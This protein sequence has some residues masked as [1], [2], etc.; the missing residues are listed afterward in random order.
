MRI[1]VALIMV[2]AAALFLACNGDS[3]A[4]PRYG[5]NLR[6]AVTGTAGIASATFFSSKDYELQDEFYDLPTESCLPL[7][8][9]TPSPTL[10]FIDVGAQ[11]SLLS[12][13]EI[14][15]MA[16]SVTTSSV[17]YSGSAPSDEFTSRL[18]SLSI[19][20]SPQAPSA[21]IPG[22]A[23]VA[24]LPQVT[25]PA[26]F[27]SS[28]VGIGNATNLEVTWIV[29]DGPIVLRFAGNDGH[30]FACR[31]TD[32]GEF[33][34]PQASLATLSSAGVF[35]V[36]RLGVSGRST[37]NKRGLDVTARSIVSAPFAKN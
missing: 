17:F 11:I 9:A 15:N 18:F 16:R 25:S 31:A 36:I 29:A 37:Y 8:A 27:G 21:Q 22:V 4:D 5:G 19:P 23:L 30:E 33:S 10:S 2:A 32:D 13:A 35:S 26:G 12:S 24:T 6:I 28:V 14:I 1:S 3:G 20:G 34:V 7:P